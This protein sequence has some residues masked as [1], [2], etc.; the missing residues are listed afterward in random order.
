MDVPIWALWKDLIFVV[1]WPIW[2]V[3]AY[4]MIRKVHL[5]NQ[6]IFLI[7]SMIFCLSLTFGIEIILAELFFNSGIDID[8]ISDRN[9]WII[10]NFIFVSKIVM[11]IILLHFLSKVKYFNRTNK[12][13]ETVGSLQ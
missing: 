7:V 11:P 12:C 2:F 10:S 6:W 3:P 5:Q 4:I 8:E 9:F 1:Y 13:T